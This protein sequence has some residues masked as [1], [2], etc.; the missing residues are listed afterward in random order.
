MKKRERKY[1]QTREFKKLQREWYQKLED[2]GFYD[3]EGGVEGH[4]LRG[5]TST[6]A[7]S[8]VK[9]R[10]VRDR[11][12]GFSQAAGRSFHEVVEAENELL[13]FYVG[14]KARYFH[15]ASVLASQQVAKGLLPARVLYTMILH[16]RG[17]GSRSIAEILD[18]KRSRIRKDLEKIRDILLFALDSEHE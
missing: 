16:A 14:N 2:T 3:V 9:R 15:I 10:V 4:L 7:L 17:M 1:Y 13:D 6:S 5:S 8:A 18:E 12:R 11:G